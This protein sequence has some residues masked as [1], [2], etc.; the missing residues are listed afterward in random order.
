VHLELSVMIWYSSL[1]LNMVD[2]NCLIYLIVLIC[3][4]TLTLLHLYPVN[5]DSTLIV[6]NS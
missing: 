4:L 5:S 1:N 3:A 6:L 2:T